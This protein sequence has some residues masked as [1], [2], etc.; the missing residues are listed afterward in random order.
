MQYLLLEQVQLLSGVGL[1][2]DNST[3][4]SNIMAVLGRLGRQT[5]KKKEGSADILQVS[6]LFVHVYIYLGNLL[7]SFEQKPKLFFISVNTNTLK[8]L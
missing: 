1:T 8:A 4:R 7:Y 2:N 5:L 3:A 6:D